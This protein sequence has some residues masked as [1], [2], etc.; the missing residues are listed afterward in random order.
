M[1]GRVVVVLG[2]VGLNVSA[3]MTGGWPIS[4]M[5]GSFQAKVNPEIVSVQRV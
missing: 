5:N 1:T 4:S 2:D 3:G